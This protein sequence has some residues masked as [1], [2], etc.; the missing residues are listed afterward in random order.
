MKLTNKILLGLAAALLIILTYYR[1][2][3]EG[4]IERVPLAQK[5]G[6]REK[7]QNITGINSITIN[8]LLD[9]K[10]K[11]SDSSYIVLNGPDNLIWKYIKLI[12][13]NNNLELL[14]NIDLSKYRNVVKVNI[15]LKD[16]NEFKIQK[17]A[18]CIVDSFDNEYIKISAY[19]SSFVQFSNCNYNHAIILGKIIL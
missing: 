11:K 16:L 14:S 3:A 9:I 13:T 12:E 8:A 18:V 17:G 5:F 7:C 19:D 1:V 15:F 10:I 2:V 4:L 6:N